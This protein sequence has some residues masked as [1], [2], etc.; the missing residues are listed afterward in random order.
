MRPRQKG[1]LTDNIGAG[2]S[3]GRRSSGPLGATV[4]AHEQYG[5]GCL[6]FTRSDPVMQA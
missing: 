5:A 4:A 2:S 6:R 1:R 3:D